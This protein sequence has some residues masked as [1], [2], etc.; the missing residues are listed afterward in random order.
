[1]NIKKLYYY[2]RKLA[3]LKAW[4][5]L[6]PAV[7]FAVFAIQGLRG[8]YATMVSLREAVYV[9]DQQNGD[10]EGALT[11]LRAHVYSHMNTDL[12][13]GSN[14]IHP[15]IQLKARYERLAA[16]EEERVKALNTEVSATGARVCAQQFPSE[17]YN[18]PRVACIQ[19]YVA[20]NAAKTT[21]IP[22]QLYKFDFLSPNWS[23]D[24]AGVSILL[25]IVFF[26][27]FIARLLLEYYLRRKIQ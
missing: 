15:P 2:H 18:A 27:L 14:P 21:H 16:A 1:M 6:I 20:A 11:Q 12:A 26:V 9:A 22:E 5:F 19:D 25:S 23:F 8:N 24:K 13:S 7:L 4:Y 10:V 3:R 17:G